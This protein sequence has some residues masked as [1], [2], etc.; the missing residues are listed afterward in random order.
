MAAKQDAVDKLRYEDA[1]QQIEA[2][3]ERIESGEVGLEA[4]MADCEK[5][6]KLIAHCRSIL[7]T[8]EKRIAQLL[9][10]D[11]GG[12]AVEGE[13]DEDSGDDDSEGDSAA[14]AG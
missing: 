9:T 7:G 2:I 6:L 3:I 1:V 5:G 14:D 13:L 4:T 8:A 10:D 12:L 11:R